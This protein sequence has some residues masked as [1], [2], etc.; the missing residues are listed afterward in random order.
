MSILQMAKLKLLE[1]ETMSPNS[2][3]QSA[4]ELTFYYR[5]ALIPDFQGQ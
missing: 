4:V 5:S 3:S 1:A 2:H